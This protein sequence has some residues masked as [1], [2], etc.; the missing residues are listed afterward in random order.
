MR[1]VRPLTWVRL[2]SDWQGRAGGHI[3]ASIH[4]QSDQGYTASSAPA[5]TSFAPLFT[6]EAAQE[7]VQAHW[8]SFVSSCIQL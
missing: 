4:Y 8:D 1:A 2:G 7:A 6:L 5:F 3:V